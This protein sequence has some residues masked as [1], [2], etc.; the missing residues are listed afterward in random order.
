M[1]YTD[2]PRHFSRLDSADWSWSCQD[3]CHLKCMC[4]RNIIYFQDQLSFFEYFMHFWIFLDTYY[5]CRD[6]PHNITIYPVY[7]YVVLVLARPK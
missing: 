6:T 5:G 2:L 4:K 7:F 1:I 3:F